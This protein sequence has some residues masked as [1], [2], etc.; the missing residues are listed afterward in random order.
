VKLLEELLN[1]LGVL[2]IIKAVLAM[3][4]ERNLRKTQSAIILVPLILFLL[5]F[6]HKRVPYLKLLTTTLTKTAKR[7]RSLRL[8]RMLMERVLI[9]YR[10]KISLQL[11]L[12]KWINIKP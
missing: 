10:S 8:E 2:Y 12:K 9:K 6:L 4:V 11:K 7:E 3:P 5:S 1:R